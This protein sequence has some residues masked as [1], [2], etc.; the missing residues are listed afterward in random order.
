MSDLQNLRL[1]FK[2]T[3]FFLCNRTHISY[4]TSTNN[5]SYDVFFEIRGDGRHARGKI[6]STFRRDGRLPGSNG[7]RTREGM[8]KGSFV[9]HTSGRSSENRIRW[10]AVSAS[11]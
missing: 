2:T 3:S 1:V 8:F 11:A 5:D 4:S 9:G 6:D 7:Q 10:T